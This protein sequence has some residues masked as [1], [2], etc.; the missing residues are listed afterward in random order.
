MTGVVVQHIRQAIRPHAV[1]PIRD[2]SR[3]VTDDQVASVGTFVFV[4]FACFVV[5]SFLMSLYGLDA[6]TAMSATITAL[7]NIGPGVAESIGPSGTF[8]G[9][10]DT[11]KLI[12]AV[13]MIAGRLEVISLLLLFMPSFYR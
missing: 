4:Y 2:G 7:G 10:P 8:Q 13:A 12:M 6:A 11:A 9:M 3:I 1:S 5:V